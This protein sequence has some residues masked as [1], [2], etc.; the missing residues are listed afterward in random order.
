MVG[1]TEDWSGI[2]IVAAGNE[3]VVG[4][5]VFDDPSLD[6]QRAVCRIGGRC[7]RLPV[8]GLSEAL[9]GWPSLE[10]RLR[11]HQQATAVSLLQ[12]LLCFRRHG[13]DPR[14]ASWLLQTSDRM[15]RASFPLTHAVLASMLGVRRP[16]VSE[17]AAALQRAGLIRYKPSSSAAWV[18]GR[19]PHPPGRCGCRSGV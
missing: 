3:A 5:P 18:I 7:L 6:R 9:L 2:D 4:W 15:G 1:L 17:S 14:C 11:R 8:E 10:V 19:R 12:L 13:R 16:S